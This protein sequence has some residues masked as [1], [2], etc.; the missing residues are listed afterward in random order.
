LVA[1]EA[2]FM[3]TGTVRWFSNPK[4]YGFITSDEGGKDL[5]IDQSNIV[6]GGHKSLTEGAKVVFDQ[7]EGAKG[8]EALRLS[9]LGLLSERFPPAWS[10]SR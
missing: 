7:H 1:K 6:G 10:R 4:G 8:I 5:F 2:F 3:A 9:R